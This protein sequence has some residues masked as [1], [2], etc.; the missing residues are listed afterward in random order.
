VSSFDGGIFKRR[1]EKSREQFFSEKSGN[2]GSYGKPAQPT[3]GN[4]AK[5]LH[6]LS[7]YF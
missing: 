6:Q 7:V 1:F 4:F 5:S 3:P 2:Q